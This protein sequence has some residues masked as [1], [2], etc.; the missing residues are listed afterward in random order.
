MLIHSSMEHVFKNRTDGRFFL[1]HSNLLI[2]S[3]WHNRD[4]EA[5]RVG[6][7][8]GNRHP[9]SRKINNVIG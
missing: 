4:F 2:R 1:E 8:V 5:D 9:I 3:R 7:N 6:K